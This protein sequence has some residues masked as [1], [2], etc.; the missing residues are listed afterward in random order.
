[1]Y[2]EFSEIL[3]A[4]IQC[5]EIEMIEGY[6]DSLQQKLIDYVLIS[7]HSQELHTEVMRK[8]DSFG[9]RVEVS[10]DFDHQTTSYNGFVFASSPRKEALFC[11]FSP[12]GRTQIA[13]S[14]SCDL[15][16]MLSRTLE[17]KK[18]GH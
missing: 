15:V 10:A 18:S 17:T 12:P 9:N 3:H 8:L 11:N 2:G 5:Y 7:T 4:N 16:A 1:M 14:G 6:R 13:Q